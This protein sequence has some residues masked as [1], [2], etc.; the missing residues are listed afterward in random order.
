[1][2][3]PK[4]LSMAG[5]DNGSRSCD[6][7]YR[8]KISAPR[9]AVRAVA[10]TSTRRTSM[11]RRRVRARLRLRRWVILPR[12][13]AA[14]PSSPRSSSVTPALKNAWPGRTRRS[15]RVRE[16]TVLRNDGSRKGSTITKM[17]FNTFN[18]ARIFSRFCA[19]FFVI[20]LMS[21]HEFLLTWAQVHSNGMFRFSL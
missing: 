9:A 2:V 7:R 1:M 11:P 15:G 4:Q 10:T 14:C 20:R 19:I 18:L 3:V 5:S 13:A 17:I 21:S 8:C 16:G 12:R 6:I